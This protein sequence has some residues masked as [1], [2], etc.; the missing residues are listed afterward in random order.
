LKTNNATLRYQITKTDNDLNIIKNYIGNINGFNKAFIEKHSSRSDNYA[1]YNLEDTKVLLLNNLDV[2]KLSRENNYQNIKVFVKD[3]KN[4]K[5]YHITLNYKNTFK[6]LMFDTSL[7]K[8]DLGNVKIYRKSVIK[9]QKQDLNFSLD[10][11]EKNLYAATSGNF[12]ESN[13]RTAELNRMAI[14]IKKARTISPKGQIIISEAT[15]LID[16]KLENDDIIEIID[17]KKIV[18]VI[19][20]VYFPNTFTIKETTTIAEVFGWSGGLSE[21]ADED[22]IFIL[23]NN[24]FITKVDSFDEILPFDSTIFV[25]KKLDSKMFLF[26]KDIVDVVYK[27]ALSAGVMLRP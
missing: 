17:N 13:I 22:K 6:Q 14:F 2:V 1:V 7:L 15:D 21:N 12:E 18:N 9:K 23:S 20:E 26:A 19:G 5:Q 16:L 24:G 4:N 25:M 11:L 10:I 8:D 27:V 3:N